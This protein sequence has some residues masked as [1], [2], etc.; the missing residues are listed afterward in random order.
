MTAANAIP[1][2]GYSDEIIV[3]KLI[4]FRYFIYLFFQAQ[5]PLEMI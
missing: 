1:H 4:H 5:F 2:F 3:D